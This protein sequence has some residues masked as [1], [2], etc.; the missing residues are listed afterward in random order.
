MKISKNKNIYEK[1][2]KVN[3]RNPLLNESTNGKVPAK[4]AP[5]WGPQIVTKMY[6]FEQ[7]V[8]FT[9][10]KCIFSTKDAAESKKWI[11]IAESQFRTT[12]IVENL[13]YWNVCTRVCVT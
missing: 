1:N 9:V 2:E 8:K 3:R 10:D 4:V 11:T 6:F 5:F 13:K 12:K 7:K